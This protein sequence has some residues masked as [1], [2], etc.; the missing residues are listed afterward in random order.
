MAGARDLHQ[1]EYRHHQTN[2]LSPVASSMTSRESLAGWDSR[3]RAWVRHPHADKLSESACYQVFPNGQAALAWR[4][5]DAR[6]ASRQDGTTGRP[7]VS[8]VLVGPAGVLTPEVALAS[9]RAGLSA[10]WAGPLPGQVPDGSELPLVSEE[11]LMTLTRQMTPVLDQAAAKQEGLQ[12]VVA[13]ALTEPAAPLAISIHDGLIQMPLGE[14]VQIPLLWGL[15][16]I[17]TPLLGPAGRGW[18]FSTFELPLGKTDPK[19]LPG[20]V[21][22][23]A[24]E[25]AKAPPSRWRREAK[26]RPFEDGAL[27]DGTSYAGMLEQAGWLVAE[28]RE[29]G[30]AGLEQF[31]TE[32]GGSGGSFATRLGQ[33]SEML[34]RAYQPARAARQRPAN[35]C[36]PVLAAEQADSRPAR[37][38]APLA[39][40]APADPAVAGGTRRVLGDPGSDSAEAGSGELGS[41][42]GTDPEIQAA[43]PG[44]VQYADPVPGES[45]TG[46]SPPGDRRA[47][48]SRPADSRAGET[49]GQWAEPDDA[50]TGSGAPSGA[51]YPEPD[52]LAAV[53]LPVADSADDVSEPHPGWAEYGYGSS[54]PPAYP[55]APAREGEQAPALQLSRRD[56]TPADTRPSSGGLRNPSRGSQEPV[57]S[58]LKQ[59]ELLG[60]DQ[61]LFESLLDQI[62]RVNDMTPEERGRSWDVISSNGWYENICRNNSFRST[63]LSNVFDVVVIPAL[64]EQPSV[65]VLATWALKA[66]VPMVEGLL[67]AARMAGAEMNNTV[68]EILEPVLAYRWTVDNFMK[69]YWDSRRIVRSYAGP[70]RD[71]GTRGFLG[72]RRKSGRRS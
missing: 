32:R 37:A 21:F 48:M 60:E 14:G 42:L 53:G 11:A 46:A 58:L 41:R 56:G 61:R 50:W 59:L 30:G 49:P 27:D 1:I 24:Q 4:Y 45:R 20:I 15:R 25:G 29:R 64:A 22:R 5:W 40:S 72:L 62:C 70:G 10:E 2:D 13:A 8:R 55:L 39:A 12:A 31:I 34:R 23:A 66:P 26:V 7:L 67:A 38:E 51:Q 18:S 65:E 54:Q 68:M 47:G 6:A 16:R 43:R 63:D 35:E 69:D 33:V 19:S 57:S 9:C 52:S 71:D 17:A 28:Y 44:D 3:I 36:S